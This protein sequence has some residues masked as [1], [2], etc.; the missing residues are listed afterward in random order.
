[1][2]ALLHTLFGA[3]FRMGLFYFIFLKFTF[4]FIIRHAFARRFQQ[5]SL[6]CLSQESK[7]VMARQTE[8]K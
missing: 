4:T 1:M 3:I 6:G 5:P 7:N 2:A 8:S